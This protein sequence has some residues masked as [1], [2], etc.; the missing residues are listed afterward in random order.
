MYF[1][2]FILPVAT[3]GHKISPIVHLGTLKY[4]NGA[5]I[6]FKVNYISLGVVYWY[7]Y[8]IIKFFYFISLIATHRNETIGLQI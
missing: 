1:H 5:S 4:V 3:H 2:I 6:L 8:F 7:K